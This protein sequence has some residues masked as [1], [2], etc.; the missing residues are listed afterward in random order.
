MAGS[1]EDSPKCGTRGGKVKPVEMELDYEGSEEGCLEA[2]NEANEEAAIGTYIPQCKQDGTWEET[3]CWGSTGQ[4]WCVNRISGRKLVGT[5]TGVGMGTEGLNCANPV[6][7]SIH[8]QHAK[9]MS[10]DRGQTKACFLG[11]TVASSVIL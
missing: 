5:K 4:C 7:Q 6:L 10:N 1:G 8:P 2:K 11:I 3:Q 9:S